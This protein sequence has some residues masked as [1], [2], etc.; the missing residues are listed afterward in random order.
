M[1]PQ[2]SANAPTPSDR[3]PTGID[4]FRRVVA[5]IHAMK[6]HCAEQGIPLTDAAAEAIVTVETMR[7][8]MDAPTTP[9]A[10]DQPAPVPTA[11]E[12]AAPAPAAP[13]APVTVDLGAALRAAWT[14]HAR[15][16]ELVRPATPASIEWSSARPT[17]RA[18]RERRLFLAVMAGSAVAALALFVWSLYAD[19]L[20]QRDGVRVE[21]LLRLIERVE[22]PSD[23]GKESAAPPDGMGL[24]TRAA[25][26]AA[27]T[28][29]QTRSGRS[30]DP[31]DALF[32]R[33]RVAFEALARAGERAGDAPERRDLA[34]LR[35][36]LR[37][38]APLRGESSGKADLMV[39]ILAGALGAAFYN[40]YCTRRYIV[41][42]TFDRAQIASY[43]VRVPLG[44]LAGLILGHFGGELVESSGTSTANLHLSS[45]FLALV[46]G[47][48]VEAVHLILLRIADTLAS[49][50]RGSPDDAVKAGVAEL[51]V[52]VLKELTA[53]ALAM[54][55]E[56]RGAIEALIS[57]F[58][59]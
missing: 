53:L 22:P 32:A 58:R 18:G 56:D 27:L 17:Q 16:A 14:A 29:D 33:S 11:P 55:A 1:S 50:V 3:T 42:R 49:L 10:S 9:V 35:E 44:M 13:V 37:L 8:A 40:L 41:E 54:P 48:S 7:E 57:K 51:K 20:D 15:L 19:M 59:P 23:G 21:A 36:D 12:P 46:G 24:A 43:L 34:A 30:S 5:L 26:A 25:D 4:Q 52:D 39:L 2:P 38:V 28:A 45:A 47:Y 31:I 6:T